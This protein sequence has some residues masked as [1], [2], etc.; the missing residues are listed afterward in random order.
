MANGYNYSSYTK[1]QLKA[2][3]IM[4]SYNCFI[5][6][7]VGKVEVLVEYEVLILKA[8]V[9]HSQSVSSPLLH[10]WIAAEKCGTVICAHC[11]LRGRDK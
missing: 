2:Y 10:L 8:T 7:W 3:K 6:D 5:Q 1:E 11:T 4:D 9:R